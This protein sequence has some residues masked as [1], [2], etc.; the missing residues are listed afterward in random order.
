MT[1]LGIRLACL[2]ACLCLATGSAGA[3]TAAAIFDFDFTDTSLEASPSS[4][5]P[6]E[7]RRLVLAA[8]RLR[9]LLR[10]A[11]IAAVDLGPARDRIERARP[12]RACNGCEAEV[13]RELGAALAVTGMVH[14]V[15]NLILTVDVMI[16][17]ARTGAVLRTG[18][19]DIRGN[20]DES[21]LRGVG[22]VVRNR[23]LDPPL[24]AVEP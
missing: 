17:D 24:A 9:E 6:D 15:S 12:L 14:K 18:R 10:E 2:A 11:G 16:R 8:D 3:E 23:L 22:Y 21:W 20:T 7:A 13:A 1:S 5:R 4:V 19:A